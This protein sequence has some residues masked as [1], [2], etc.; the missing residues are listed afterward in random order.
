MSWLRGTFISTSTEAEE[1]MASQRNIGDQHGNETKSKGQR[2]KLAAEERKKRMVMPNQT[3]V[4]RH[5]CI[6]IIIFF[7]SFNLTSSSAC[8]LFDFA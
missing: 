2:E 7:I 8:L 3:L 4:S 5:N 6:V 1:L